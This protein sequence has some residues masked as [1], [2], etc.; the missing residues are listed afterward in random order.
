DRVAEWVHRN[1]DEAVQ[2]PILLGGEQ[3]ARDI[4]LVGITESHPEASLPEGADKEF[5][6]SEPLKKAWQEWSNLRDL[7]PAPGVYTPHQW[8]RYQATLLRYEQLLRAGDPT[9]KA[10]GLEGQLALLK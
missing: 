3:R 5:V 6:P 9:Q 4:E 8:R 10:G 1:R 7:V 2:T